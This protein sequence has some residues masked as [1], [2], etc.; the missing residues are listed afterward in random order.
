MELL[1]RSGVRG[2]VM[3]E[4]VLSFPTVRT[5]NLVL[6]GTPEY[7]PIVEKLLAKTPLTL[8]YD[9]NL[10]ELVIARRTPQGAQATHVSPA[11]Q[12]G[13]AVSA[14]GLVTVLPSEG[15]KAGLRSIVFSGTTSAG[16]QAAVDYFTSP[17]HLR[18][19]VVSLKGVPS[20]YQ[21]VVETTADSTIA[22]TPRYHSHQVISQ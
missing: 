19:L 18:K 15:K 13:Q 6:F 11:R 12:Q 16:T 4:R 22:L 17:E 10:R 14:F 9:P 20:A 21:V 1:G 2:E 3:P 7:S 5:K 8:H